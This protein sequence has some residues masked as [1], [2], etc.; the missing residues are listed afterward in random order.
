MVLS[1]NIAFFVI[2]P[3]RIR[4]ATQPQGSRRATWHQWVAWIGGILICAVNFSDRL[5]FSAPWDPSVLTVM[6]V[7]LLLGLFFH[8][9]YT[10]HR[11]LF[12]SKVRARTD[13]A[14][15]RIRSEED[16]TGR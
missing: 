15:L 2:Y 1:L 10:H 5:T 14:K 6:Y 13:T 16:R 3:N 12:A 11:A 7:I 9:A 4:D 8:M